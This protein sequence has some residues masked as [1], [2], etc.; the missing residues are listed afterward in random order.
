MIRAV[1]DHR[2]D[3]LALH[4]IPGGESVM[5]LSLSH[6]EVGSTQV[7]VG[8]GEQKGPVEGPEPLS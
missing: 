6:T 7:R 3:T 5:C 4:W 8:M 2:G 1:G